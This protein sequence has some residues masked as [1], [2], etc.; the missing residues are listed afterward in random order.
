MLTYKDMDTQTPCFFNG[1]EQVSKYSFYNFHD[2]KRW[3]VVIVHL[4]GLLE[5]LSES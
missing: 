2:F 1:L 3:G 5:W 4:M